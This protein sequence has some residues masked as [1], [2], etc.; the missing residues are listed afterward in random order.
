MAEETRAAGLLRQSWRPERVPAATAQFLLVVRPA[1]WKLFSVGDKQPPVTVVGMTA[2]PGM[3]GDTSKPLI[4]QD[5][6]NN[7]VFE[8]PVSATPTC[9]NTVK[10]QACCHKQEKGGNAYAKTLKN[11]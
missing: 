10:H 7:T 2:S 5:I 8:L 9:R 3:S 6:A 4:P 11:L 1:T